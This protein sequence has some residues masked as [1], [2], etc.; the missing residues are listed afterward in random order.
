MNMQKIITVIAIIMASLGFMPAQSKADNMSAQTPTVLRSGKNDQ[1]GRSRVRG[2]R[3]KPT[4]SSYIYCS[5]SSEHICFEL[6]GDAD[7]MEVIITDAHGMT[8]T[9]IVTQ[10]EPCCDIPPM[11]S[12]AQ[13]ECTVDMNTTFT[14]TLFF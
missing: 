13:I 1:P 5:Y 6:P 8:W 11:A 9:S 3:L 2:N 10:D 4:I 7:F 12:P 14:G